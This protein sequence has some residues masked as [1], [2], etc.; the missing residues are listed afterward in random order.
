M[1]EMQEHPTDPPPAGMATAAGSNAG[2]GNPAANPGSAP[3]NGPGHHQAPP[4]T[5]AP[6]QSGMGTGPAAGTPAPAAGLANAFQNQV[7]QAMTPAI[8][9]AVRD[10]LANMPSSS[11]G[12][13][14]VSELQALMT[15]VAAAVAAATR[16]NHDGNGGASSGVK[17]KQPERYDGETGDSEQRY[18]VHDFLFSLD[19]YFD[20]SSERN[21]Q[22]KAAFA[23]SCLGGRARSFWR[24]HTRTM[25]PATMTYAA[26]QQ[27][28]RTQYGGAKSEYVLRAELR[29]LRQTGTMRDYVAD[30]TRLDSMIRTEPLSNGDRIYQFLDGLQS[31]FRDRLMTQPNGEP[32]TEPHALY[33]QAEIIAA[34]HDADLN[35]NKKNLNHTPNNKLN[36]A[37]PAAA[38]VDGNAKNRN[39]KRPGEDRG[40]GDKPKKQAK[41]SKDLWLAKDP[42]SQRDF[43]KMG[44]CYVCGQQGHR[45]GDC[46][47]DG[48]DLKKAQAKYRQKIN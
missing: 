13:I 48:D 3:A 19:N 17:P 18:S 25:N 15:S 8:H 20:L 23:V 28:M 29:K 16:G 37:P 31:R 45:I 44:R 9:A 34:G 22:K 6:G 10:V 47:L 26:F 36:G 46:T 7:L 14:P 43:R 1:E 12:T 11:S 33:R 21:E 32:W 39:G 27:I 40:A 2:A 5:P 35:L 42:E 41:V 38:G 4:A 30:F 24:D